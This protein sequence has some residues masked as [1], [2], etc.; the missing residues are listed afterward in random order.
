MSDYEKAIKMLVGDV[1]KG[2]PLQQSVMN[3]YE[4]IDRVMT[5]FQ[6]KRATRLVPEADKPAAEKALAA[7]MAREK[8]DQKI[9]PGPKKPTPAIKQDKERTK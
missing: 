3:A 6:M 7:D 8:I 4:D 5:L 2:K 9:K 1:K